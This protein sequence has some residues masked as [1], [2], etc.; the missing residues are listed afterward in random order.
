MKRTITTALAVAGLLAVPA[1]SSAATD[2]GSRMK[3]DPTDG[4]CKALIAP[5]TY[6]SFIHPSDPDGDPYSGGAPVDGVI[7]KFRIRAYGDNGAPGQATFRLAEVTATPNAPTALAKGVGT[8]PTVTI[9]ASTGGGDVPISEFAARLRVK[10]GDHLALDTSN[11]NAIYNSN[12]NKYTYVFAPTL[13]DGGGA[14]GSNDVT[15][16]LLVAARIEPD[17]DRDGFGDE[18]Q[19]NCRRRRRPAARATRPSRASPRSS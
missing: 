6:A 16:E 17:A 11:V 9:P 13:A 2:F 5:C 4:S 18:T 10:K 3:N 15:N 7:T 8:G 1:A 14:R 19:D 12:G